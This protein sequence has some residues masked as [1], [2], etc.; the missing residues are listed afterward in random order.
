MQRWLGG[1]PAP[2]SEV[3]QLIGLRA[4]GAEIDATGRGS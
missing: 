3:G 1:W 4:D 2:T